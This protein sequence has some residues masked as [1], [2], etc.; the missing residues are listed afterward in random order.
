[1]ETSQINLLEISI[2]NLWKILKEVVP[3]LQCVELLL[4]CYS[5]SATGREVCQPESLHELVDID[6][7]VLVEVDAGRQVC[8]GLVADVY[9]EVG[10]KELPGLTKL[11][12]RNGTLMEKKGEYCSSENKQ[13]V[14][15]H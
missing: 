12:V 15:W 9:L 1:M 10:A 14:E 3:V 11:L 2:I 7:A 5:H 6:A 4:T 8:Y 13:T